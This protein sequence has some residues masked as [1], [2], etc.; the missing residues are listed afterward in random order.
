MRAT[1]PPTGSATRPATDIGPALMTVETCHGEPVA[2]VVVRLRNGRTVEVQVPAADE[3]E[4]EDE[5]DGRREDGVGQGRRPL[6]PME[7]RIVDVLRFAGG[8]M[9][10]AEI[11]A[12]IDEA[13]DPYGGNF[14]RAI[15]RLKADEVIVGGRS[16]G[17]FRLKS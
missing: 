7:Q 4:D 8:P 6:D 12:E 5:G 11:A 10:Q 13:D 1:S 16:D 17:G 15:D 9:R 3:D 14:K 2:S